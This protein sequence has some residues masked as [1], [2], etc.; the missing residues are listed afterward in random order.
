LRQA[1]VAKLFEEAD[2]L[3]AARDPDEVKAELADLFEIVRSLA[4]TTGVEWVEVENA[5]KEKRRDRGGFET[6]AVLVETSWPALRKPQY[7]GQQALSFQ[8]L[9]RT[10]TIGDVAKMSFNA[11][12]AAGSQGTKA[13]VGDRRLVVRLARDGVE[14]RMTARETASSDAQLLLPFEELI[15]SSEPRE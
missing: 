10:V 8:D 1:L 3:L 15:E 11:L 5:A 14:I 9:A 4:I 2:E 7:H 6:G 12:V 13:T